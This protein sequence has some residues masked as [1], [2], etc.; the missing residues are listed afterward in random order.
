MPK[1]ATTRIVTVKLIMINDKVN[2][3]INC[4]CCYYVRKFHKCRHACCVENGKL[5][6]NDFHPECFKT[7]ERNMFFNSKCTDIVDNA[8]SVVEEHKSYV[9]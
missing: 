7:Y 8:R 6:P 2:V 5:E 3:L 4:D 1:H 9:T